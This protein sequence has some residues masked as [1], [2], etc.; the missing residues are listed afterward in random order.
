M[1]SKLH[2]LAGDT[3][4]PVQV[5]F[6]EREKQRLERKERKEQRRQEQVD[7]RHY[8]KSQ[9]PSDDRSISSIIENQLVKPQVR[10]EFH[11][12]HLKRQ[13]T[14]VQSTKPLKNE[15]IVEK[16]PTV[17]DELFHKRK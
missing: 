3:N 1:R 16:E 6:E 17:S 8:Q 11:R 13:Q 15:L 2:D 4:A 9:Q 7:F 10:R 12:E 5:A 14:P